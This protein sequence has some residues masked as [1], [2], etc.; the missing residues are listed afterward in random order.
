MS[1]GSYNGPRWVWY[2]PV[3]DEN[4]SR[5]EDAF[6]CTDAEDCPDSEIWGGACGFLV[7]EACHQPMRDPERRCS[8]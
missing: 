2:C 7:C 4:R 6:V 5:G 8:E 3:C 1:A